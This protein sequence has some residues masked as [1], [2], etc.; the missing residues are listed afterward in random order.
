VEAALTGNWSWNAEYL[1]ADRG[2]LDDPDAPAPRI[3]SV[4]GGQILT[5]T[6]YTDSIVRVGLNYK[7]Q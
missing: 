5:H 2:S 3:T 7:F 1:F 6:K 4:S